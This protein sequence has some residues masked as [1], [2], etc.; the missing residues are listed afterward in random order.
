MGLKTLKYFLIANLIKSQRCRDYRNFSISRAV[1]GTSPN[2]EIDLKHTYKTNILL[3]L[4]TVCQPLTTGKT[5]P[6]PESNPTAN[7]QK[8]Y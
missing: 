7:R 1:L 5:L 4:F 8:V 2:L 3:H 6:L